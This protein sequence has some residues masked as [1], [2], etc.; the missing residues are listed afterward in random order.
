VPTRT[1]E[2]TLSAGM[3]FEVVT[4]SGRRF[5][6]DDIAE[7]GLGPFESV[8]TALAA[9]SAM[10]VIS[11]ALK[12]R[13]DVERYTV[14]ATGEQREEYPKIYTRIDLVH[15]VVGVALDSA[16]IQR[17]IELSATKYCPVNA[18]V[19]AGAT[20]VHHRYRIVRPG[21][22]P[23]EGLVLITGPYRPPDVVS[24]S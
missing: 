15:E 7:D 17:C 9:C 22:P 18:M 11:I 12:K 14:H 2:L 23:E 6:Y 19:S 5:A 10:D 13:Q 20:A 4:G 21:Q 8:L 24:D 16:A 3:H 1:A